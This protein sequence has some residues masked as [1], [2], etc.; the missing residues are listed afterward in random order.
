MGI[1]PLIFKTVSCP[2]GIR[3]LAGFLVNCRLALHPLSTDMADMALP[4]L[5]GTAAAEEDMGTAVGTVLAEEDT[6]RVPRALVGAGQTTSQKVGRG[7][8]VNANKRRHG[9]R[10]CTRYCL[11][12]HLWNWVV[13]RLA[14]NRTWILIKNVHV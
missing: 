5:V 1:P 3:Y 7:R 12:K 2:G 9:R 14:P 6:C 8:R 11:C 10:L 13:S 4:A